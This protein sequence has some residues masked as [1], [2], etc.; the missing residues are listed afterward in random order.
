MNWNKGRKAELKDV[1]NVDISKSVLNLSQRNYTPIEIE[2]EETDNNDV[3]YLPVVIKGIASTDTIK[4]ALL[5]LVDE[6]DNSDEVNLFS[7]NGITDWMDKNTRNSLKETLNVVERQGENEYT[8]WLANTP[9]TL[10][11]SYIREFLDDLEV[12]AIRCYQTTSRHTAEINGINN[13]DALFKYDISEGYPEK[14][15]LVL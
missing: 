10:P 2:G 11:I 4:R 12:Y 8:L 15:E 14:I 7:I 6:Y 9:L 3:E 5:A 1:E 13:R